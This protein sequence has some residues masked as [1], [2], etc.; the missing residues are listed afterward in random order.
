MTKTKTLTAAAALAAATALAG[1][2]LAQASWTMTT[3]WPSSLELIEIDRH[4]VELANALTGDDLTI[5]FYEGGSPGARGR[6]VRRRRERHHPGRGRLAGL[7]GRARRG[8]LAAR[9]DAEPLQRDRLRQLDRAV[10][11]G[12]ALR[13][14]LRPVRH[15]LPALRG[16]QQRVGLP[17]LDADPHVGGSAGQAPA[18]LGAG[19]GAH[20]GAA[21]RQP[22]LHGGGRDL[23]G[24]GARGDRRGRVLHPQ[25]GLLG[26]LPAG[27]GLLGDAGLAPVGLDVRG[28]DQ[29]ARPGTR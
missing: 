13:R 8:L 26:R 11:R 6:G 24:A 28:D 23:S 12:R 29:Q 16:H 21:G 4:F 10:G 18:R 19:A 5:D 17:L 14:D 25:R 22:G 20:P 15:G 1:P 3:T 2:A 7:L 27:D 9:H